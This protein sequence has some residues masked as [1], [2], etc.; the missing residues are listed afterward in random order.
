MEITIEESSN[1]HIDINHQRLKHIKY[2]DQQIEIVKKLLNILN[3]N[4]TNK[5]FTTLEIKVVEDDILT[6]VSDILLYFSV[7]KW[8]NFR[9]SIRNNKNN[10]SFSVKNN[11]LIEP[12]PIIKNIFKDYNIKINNCNKQKMV[13][14][15]TSYFTIYTIVSDISDYI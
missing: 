3:I 6:L 14:G 2:K 15:I 8:Y 1:N 12:L 13:N 10:E 9:K 4:E 7:S 5:S 11:Q